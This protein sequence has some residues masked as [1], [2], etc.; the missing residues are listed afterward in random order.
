MSDA[1]S[2]V[3]IG[4]GPGGLMAADYLSAQGQSVDIYER[5]PSVGR[6]FLMAGRGGLNLTHSEDWSDFLKR[7][8]P[9]P[10]ALERALDAFRA[11]DLRQWCEDLGQETFI[12]SSGRVFPTAMKASP[13]LRAWLHRLSGRGVRLH[14]RHSWVGWDADKY[15]CFDTPHGELKREARAV[16]IA[17]GG[18]SW[19]RLG[20]DGQALAVLENTGVKVN[21]P[22]P[23]NCGLVLPW[24]DYLIETFQGSP[25]K[26]TRFSVGERA[27]RGEAVLTAYGLEGGAIYALSQAVRK[28]LASGSAQ[29]SLDLAP[30]LDRAALASRLSQ[31]KKGQSLSNSLRKAARLTPVQAA[32]LRESQGGPLVSAPEALATRIKSARFTIEGFQG[33]ER[34]IST[35]GGI[36]FDALTPDFMLRE[37]KGV[38]VA[39][40]MLDWDAPTG[41]YL[42]QATFATAIAAAKGCLKYISM[43]V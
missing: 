35:A 15:L 23:S 13:L 5:M 2:I 1:S 22:T 24:S 39:G 16:I 8:D 30:D 20:S 11:Q 43:R 37:Q 38:F 10:P 17:T 33:F 29:L 3:I 12:G 36:S 31:V 40:E 9:L 21:T 4:A 28:A 27:V 34:A 6:K 7:Y 41:G 32:L 26:A 19:P 42:L 25:I 18:L 14:T